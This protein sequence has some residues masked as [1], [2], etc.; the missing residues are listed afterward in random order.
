MGNIIVDAG[1]LV[2]SPVSETKYVVA[3]QREK[4]PNIAVI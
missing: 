4:D 2:R 1:R 3:S